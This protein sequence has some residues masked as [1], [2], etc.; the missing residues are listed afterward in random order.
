M[1]KEGKNELGGEKRVNS[2]VSEWTVKREKWKNRENI[3]YNVVESVDRCVSTNSQDY[4][5]VLK[6]TSQI[7]GHDCN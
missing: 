7:R 2:G 3:V 1:Q 5:G 6:P 4:A